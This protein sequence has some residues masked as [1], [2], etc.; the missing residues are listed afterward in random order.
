MGTN[1]STKSPDLT[2][3][4]PSTKSSKILAQWF[5]DIPVVVKYINLV[6]YQT[7]NNKPLKTS[8]IKQCIPA[9]ISKIESNSEYKIV[10]LG[11]TV[12][13]ALAMTKYDFFEAPHPSGLNRK[14]NDK[15]YVEQMIQTLREYCEQ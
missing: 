8:E 13:K 6:D 1:P 14:L 15:E 5:K 9:L 4:H 10:G 12:A 7:E 3:F 2:P 11:K